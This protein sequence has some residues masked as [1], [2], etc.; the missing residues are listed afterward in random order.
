M[1]KDIIAVSNRNLCKG[2]LTNQIETICKYEPKGVMLREKNLSENEYKTLAIEVM[3]IC[4]S[5]QVPCILHNYVEVARDLA[6][7]N[8]HLPMN[9]FR[10]CHDNLDDFK[11]IGA[12]IHSVEEAL[13]AQK[14]GANYI[15]AGHIYATDCKKGLAPRG[16]EYLMNICDNVTIPVY[17]IGG[18]SLDKEQIGYMKTCG[19]AGVCIMSGMM[20]L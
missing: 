17:A 10:K 18:I 14:L 19:A 8:I 9:I 16:P 13:E 4:T 6:C 5:Y 11:C 1:Y 3:D 12:S 7:E 15:T 2:P 20:E